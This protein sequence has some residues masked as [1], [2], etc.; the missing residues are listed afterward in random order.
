MLQNAVQ[1]LDRSMRIGR[2]VP[3]ARLIEMMETSVE[4]AGMAAQLSYLSVL[5]NLDNEELQTVEIACVGAGIGAESLDTNKL[6][7]LNFRQAIKSDDVSDWKK[8]IKAEFDQFKKLILRKNLPENEKVLMTTWVFKH[9]ANATR[10]GRLNARGYK[11]LEGE[12]FLAD[13]ISSPVTNPA[14][15]RVLIRC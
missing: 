6:Q 14:T 3:P 10:R 9:K 8:E 15:I 1:D 4:L 13:S 7:V 5:Q 11:Q 2:C 12:Q